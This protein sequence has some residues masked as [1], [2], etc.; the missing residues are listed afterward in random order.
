[1]YFCLVS[2]C[3]GLSQCNSAN[4]INVAVYAYLII[5]ANIQAACLIITF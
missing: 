2:V 3:L 1:M 5:F 4:F